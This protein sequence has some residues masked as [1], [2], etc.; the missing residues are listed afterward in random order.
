MCEKKKT[1][2]ATY[3]SA[4]RGAWV[5]LSRGR[6]SVVLGP[7]AVLE[8]PNLRIV[9]SHCVYFFF[10]F[11]FISFLLGLRRRRA[12]WL[13]LQRVEAAPARPP[14][15][16]HAPDTHRG[17][18]YLPACPPAYLRVR[19]TDRLAGRPAGRSAGPRRAR[20]APLACLSPIKL[21]PKATK[22]VYTQRKKEG[23]RSL[24]RPR[25]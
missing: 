11:L 17:S 5:S 7:P 1:S 10:F 6:R 19:F 25:E 2:T 12:G 15:R 9:P 18:V 14:A 3:L 13:L 24:F 8:K 22:T 4:A 20:P 23:S 21:R 16:A